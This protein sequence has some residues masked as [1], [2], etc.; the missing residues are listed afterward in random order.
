MKRMKVLFGQRRIMV[1]ATL[2]IL[3]LT[4]AAL[5]A[6][7]AS[8]TATAANPGNVFTAGNLAISDV[9]GNDPSTVILS[10]GL[11]RPGDVVD[12][13]VTIGNAGNVPGSFTLTKSALTGNAAMA[14]KLDFVIQEI[15][16]V[17]G[18]DIGAPKYNNKLN[19]AI[20]N[21]ALGIWA[22]GESHKYK[23]TVTWPN[24]PADDAGD[25]ALMGASCSYGFTW[26]AV[27]DTTIN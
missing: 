11:M 16:P 25:T 1:L 2:A 9:T 18:T 3:V 12:G 17:S 20:S 5:V 24:V 13:T 27:A 8:F 4:A 15:D 22:G 10:S 23:F 26:N 21:L 6:S 7:S 19:G 14:A